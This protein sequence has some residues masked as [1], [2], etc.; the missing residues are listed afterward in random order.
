MNRR[1]ILGLLASVLLAVAGA[2]LIGLMSSGVRESGGG[3]ANH[4]GQVSIP[5]EPT[6]RVVII[7]VDGLRP[8]LLLRANAPRIRSLMQR[9]A[10][11][12]WAR[13]TELS[14]TL[15]SHTSMLTGVK[16]EYHR[17]VWN[18]HIEN[19]YPV[20]PTIFEQA[21]LARDARG[22]R[23]TTCMVAGKSKFMEL[24]KPGSVDY[25][26]VYDDWDSSNL[27]VGTSAAEII[28]KHKP[29]LT[30]VHLPDIDWTGHSTGWGSAD[31]I[32]SIEE[33]DHAVGMVL[34]ALAEQG[35]IESTLIIFSADHGGQGW[36]HGPDDPRSR[37]I[38]WIIA[39]PGIKRD[40]DLARYG[41][42][43]INTEDTFATACALMN[44]PMPRYLDGKPIREALVNEELLKAAGDSNVPWEP[45][46]ETPPY[47]WERTEMP[48]HR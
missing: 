39:G 12:M 15:P 28:R 2:R 33:A 32:K 13:T 47:K 25:C 38:P 1:L 11:S 21:H 37:H 36:G 6:E 26:Q 24:N 40:C 18:H 35:I 22:Q 16:P 45:W 7:S 43:V 30:F 17:I 29:S 27:K 4:N 9:G 34:D 42:L 5:V 14:I 44:I 41:N 3:N 31:Q 46:W 20:V 19:E 23:L 10:Y 8:D 48:D